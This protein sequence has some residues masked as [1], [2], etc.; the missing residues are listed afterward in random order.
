[1]VESVV[2]SAFAASPES[3]ESPLSSA[4]SDVVVESES[5]VLAGVVELPL[6]PAAFPVVER[7][8]SA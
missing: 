5:L 7:A 1:M 3:P 2:V 4:A 8:L 6:V